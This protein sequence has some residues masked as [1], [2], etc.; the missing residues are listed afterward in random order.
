MSFPKTVACDAWAN[1]IIISVIFNFK[2]QIIYCK[3][4]HPAVGVL[5]DELGVDAFWNGTMA[6]E[7]V[8]ERGTGFDFQVR[9]IYQQSC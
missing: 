6:I 4:V 3:F 5:S 7:Y 8:F 1:T 9:A 2:V